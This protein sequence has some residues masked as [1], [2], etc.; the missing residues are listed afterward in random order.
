MNESDA[1]TILAIATL[2]TSSDGARTPVEL[3]ELQA[4]AVRLGVDAA[5]LDTLLTAGRSNMA[6]LASALSSDEARLAAY[7][8]AAAVCHVNGPPTPQES[9]FL[10]DLARSLGAVPGLPQSEATMQAAAAAASSTD[11]RQGA[12]SE[13]FILDQAMLAGACDLLPNKLASIAILPIQ[14]RMVYAIGKRHGQDFGMSHAK[15]LIAVLGISAAGNVIEGVIRGV[16]RG[17]LGGLIGRAAG[18]AAGVAVTFATTY[19][20]GQVAEQYYEQGRSLSAADLKA[21]FTKFSGEAQTIFP[22]VEARVRN[23]ASTT[24]LNSLLGNLRA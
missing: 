17:L 9:L 12:D 8:A 7:D 3:E 22:R 5:E 2:A 18:S 13:S 21:Q 20:L 6:T 14:L 4:T 24:D 23:L 10:A 16:G 1:R 11:D 15:D 19:A